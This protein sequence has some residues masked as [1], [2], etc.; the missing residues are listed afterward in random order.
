MISIRGLRKSHTSEGHAV[1]VLAGLDLEVAEGQFLAII[2]ASGSGKSTLLHILGG[3]D[4]QY[5]G[6]VSVAG[7]SLKAMSDEALSHF[8]NQSVGFVFQSFHLVP[9]LTALD[10]VRM[11]SF[12]HPKGLKAGS[13]ARAEEL[14]ERV[15]LSSKRKAL[16]S[17]LSGGER[18]RVAIARALL[19]S[20]KLL[21]C[22]EPTGNLDAQT[23]EEVISLF[24][25]LNKE[26]LTLLTVTHE[27]RVSGA[28]S[29]VLRLREGRLWPEARA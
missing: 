15:G 10:N 17:Q 2:G 11:P 19:L 16:P 21:L 26:G 6:E 1:E 12:F 13:H 5:S 18:Q 24:R 14:L 28:A 23:G 8:R 29:S 25:A 7:A 22:D 3:L 20:P 27:E 4:V 9:N